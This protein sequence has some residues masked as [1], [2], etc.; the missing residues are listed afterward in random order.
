MSHSRLNVLNEKKLTKGQEKNKC[1][2]TGQEG[3]SQSPKQQMGKL[4]HKH[5]FLDC[6]I[7]SGPRVKSKERR[8]WVNRASGNRQQDGGSEGQRRQESGR[9]GLGDTRRGGAE[10]EEDTKA[11]DPELNGCLFVSGLRTVLVS[12]HHVSQG[13]AMSKVTQG[14]DFRQAIQEP[15]SLLS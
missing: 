13:H 7:C 8:R 3:S 11:V 6:S 4:R 1:S 12:R 10:L 15:P 14:G 5:Y 9:Q 2:G